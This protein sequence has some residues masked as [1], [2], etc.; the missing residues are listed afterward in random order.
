MSGGTDKGLREAGLTRG[1]TSP[2]A[3][4]VSAET[5]VLARSRIVSGHDCAARADADSSTADWEHAAPMLGRETDKEGGKA[6]S[7]KGPERGTGC[8]TPEMPLAFRV[9]RRTLP[10]AQ[11]CSTSSEAARQS[12]F[13]SADARRTRKAAC[14]D[15]SAEL[16]DEDRPGEEGEGPGEGAGTETRRALISSIA[17]ASR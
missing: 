1:P 11:P 9:S 2:V 15:R 6:G 14:S 7:T 3:S 13:S 10:T 8:K 16:S 12:A 17:A 5:A 4:A